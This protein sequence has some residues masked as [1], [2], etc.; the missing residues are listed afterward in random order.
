M[1]LILVLGF[2]LLSFG[3]RADWLSALQAYENKQYAVAKTG[4]TNLLPLGNANAAFNLGVMAYYGEGQEVDLEQALTYFLLAEQLQH[5]QAADIVKRIYEEASTAQRA[6]AE[7]AAAKALAG[8]FIKKNAQRYQLSKEQPPAEIST[9]MPDIPNDVTRKHPF[10]Y[11]VVQFLVDGEGRVKVADAVDGFPEGAFDPYVFRTM[12]RWQYEATGKAHLMSVRLS[13]WA[14]GSMNARSANQ[15]IKGQN[16]WS[17][18]QLGSSR[19]QE[20]LGSVLNLVSMVSGAEVYID[21]DLPAPANEPDVS[22]WFES[23][24]FDINIPGLAGAVSVATNEKGEIVRLLDASELTHPAAET[25]QGMRIRGAN[26]GFFR[27]SNSLSQDRSFSR[28]SKKNSILVEQ[29]HAVH[30]EL[31]AGYWWKTAAANGDRRA[32]RILGAQREDWQFYLIQQQDPLA[33]AWHGAR[34]WLDGEKTEAKALLEQ[35]QAA[36]YKP[37]TELLQILSL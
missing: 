13:F 4:F 8:V 26:S 18:A 32:Q 34:L 22:A 33:T 3:V 20:M 36:G 9:P 6:G 11:V 29:Y 14:T 5:E 28:V 16:L 37:A 2:L 12:G 35:A 21:E 7:E 27:L 17:Y 15:I 30:Q 10:G 31:T 25:L 1:R 19:H 24:K 23:R